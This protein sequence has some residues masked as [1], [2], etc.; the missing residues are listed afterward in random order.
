MVGLLVFLLIFFAL[1]MVL[2]LYS[3]KYAN[4]Y[5]L[6]ML[7]GKKGSGKTTLITKL[8]WKFCNQGKEVFVEAPLSFE[9]ENL[10]FYDPHEIGIKVFPPDSVTFIDEV[11]ILYDNRKF[12]TLPD[13]VR[14]Y[15]K[16]QRHYRNTVYM[17][18]QDFDV[19]VK[20]RKLTDYMFLVN[21]HM[22]IF[23]VAR[24]IK[25]T[26]TIVQASAES[27]SRIADNL[28]FVPLWMQLFGV[29]ACMFTFIPKW[30][31]KF[32]SYVIEDDVEY[33]T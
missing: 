29:N 13:H 9:H 20:I 14:N 5:K 8:A 33:F 26:I 21:C 17:F 24:R 28:E 27:E 32:N 18:S 4:P 1:V 16:Y 30:V 19:D 15:F 10:H 25:R 23:S 31:N 11:G 3:R 7:F 2:M 12:K 22:N 6:I